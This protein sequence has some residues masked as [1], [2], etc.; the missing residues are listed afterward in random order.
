MPFQIDIKRTALLLLL[1]M[2]LFGAVVRWAA[3]GLLRL[4]GDTSTRWVLACWRAGGMSAAA[5]AV[6]E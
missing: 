5:S 3:D 4:G 1:G 2:Y 6:C